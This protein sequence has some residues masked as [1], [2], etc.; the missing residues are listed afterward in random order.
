MKAIGILGTMDTKGDEHRFVKTL[1]EAR[2]FKTYVVN[3]GSSGEPTLA[4]DI[5]P[6]DMAKETGV[7]LDA[8]L[9]RQDR[10]EC[11]TLI[12]E[13]VAEVIPRL[14]REGIIDGLISL[15]GGGGTAIGT[16]AMRALPIGFPKV[17]VSTLACGQVEPYIGSTDTVMFPSIT[18]V[19]GLNS[20]SK[21]IFARAAGAICGMVDTELP[22]SEDDKPVIAASMFGN[23]TDCVDRAREKLEAAGYE[24]LVFHATGTG[25]KILESLVASGM[26]S[27]VLDITTTELADEVAGGVLSA[28]PDR[29]DAAG[30][31]GVPT[32]VTPGC[33]D[34]VNFQGPETIPA[35]YKDRLFYKHNPQVT[36][37][38]TSAEE[39]K[40]LGKMI[41]EKMNAYTGPVSLLIPTE[42]ISVIGCEGQSFHDPD[43]DAALFSSLKEHLREDIPVIELEC[44]VNDDRFADACVD[45]LLRL[46]G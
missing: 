10:G 32:I 15:G 46:I 40:E 22:S 34:M 37:M 2:G 23:T 24:V 30:K 4:S 38:R 21:K 42:S 18:D 19:A 9:S 31:A 33:L 14:A 35:K 5:N 20:I 1:I 29:L 43:A 3:A 12:S 41:A 28:G 44:T 6:T 11:V 17:M 26:V 7:D 13:M 39:S 16:A 45:E 25:G 27:A 8:T 36:L